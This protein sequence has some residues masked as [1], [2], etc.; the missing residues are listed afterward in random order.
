LQSHEKEPSDIA[1]IC[2]QNSYGSY[3]DLAGTFLSQILRLA[4]PPTFE[5]C[6]SRYDY[7]SVFC[8][9]YWTD[10]THSKNTDG[11]EWNCSWKKRVFWKWKSKR[12]MGDERY[13]DESD[14]LPA[15]REM[16]CEADGLEKCGEMSNEVNSRVMWIYLERKMK[17]ALVHWWLQ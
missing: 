8:V 14:E 7:V 9:G 4:L 6:W 11:N 16:D 2:A 17:V 15:W 10:H 12:L 5:W 3:S 13:D 1:E